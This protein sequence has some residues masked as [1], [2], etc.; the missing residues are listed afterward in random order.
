MCPK[1]ENGPGDPELLN[2]EWCSSKAQINGS[3]SHN[4]AWF[5]GFMDD[6]KNPYAFVVLVEYGN[7]GSR[8]AGPIANRV[9]QAII[10]KSVVVC[11]HT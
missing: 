7:S 5:V 9:L 8:T 1:A 10:N 3:L 11:S 2:H 4:T 6:E